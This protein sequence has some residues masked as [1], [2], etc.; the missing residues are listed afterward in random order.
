MSDEQGGGGLL[1][2]TIGLLL[3]LH[4]ANRFGIAVLFGPL[5]VRYRGAYAAVGNLFSAYPLAYACSQIPVGFLADRMDPRRL[6]LLGTAGATVAGVVFALTDT[7]GVGVAARLVAGVCGAMIYTPAMTFG[8]GSFPAARRGAALGAAYAGVGLGTATSL[9]AL[10][11]LV[12][13]L[14][15]SGALLCL[16]G[17]AAV[18][19]V[20]TPLGLDIRKKDRPRGR[21][22]PGSL[23][24]QRG[25]LYLLGFSFLGFFNIYALLTWLPAYLSDGLGVSPARAGALAALVNISM[26]IS[27]P[28]VGKLSDLMSSRRPI[29]RIGALCGVAAF[30]ILATTRAVSLVLAAGVLAGIASAMTTAPMMLFAS[31][32]FGAGAAGLAVGMVN[33]VGQTGSSLSGVVFGPLLDATGSFGSIWWSCIPIGL[34]RFALLEMIRDEAG[35]GSTI[36]KAESS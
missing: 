21:S 20:V 26:T 6:I 31:E 10:P 5:R 30:V 36:L 1:I 28:L 23:L 34:V 12:E 25:F 7:Y 13:W 3:A 17:F 4:N 14:G 27:S 33:A 24:R 8:I 15:L 11:V 16:A 18:M 32:R 9:A 19:T 35:S 2:L 29:L 22:T